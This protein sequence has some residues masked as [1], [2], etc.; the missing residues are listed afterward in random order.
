[1]ERVEEREVF[2]G[3]GEGKLIKGY[4]EVFGEEGIR[5][6]EVVRRKERLCRGG[7]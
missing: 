2:W 3:V 7:D 4:Y 1:M 5:V 6:G